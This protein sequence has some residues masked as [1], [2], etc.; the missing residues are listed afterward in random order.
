MSRRSLREAY[1]ASTDERRSFDEIYGEDNKLF[2]GAEKELINPKFSKLFEEVYGSSHPNM[3]RLRE[4]E[5]KGEFIKGILAAKEG[6]KKDEKKKPEAKKE[7]TVDE[8]LRMRE[9]NDGDYHMTRSPSEDGIEG[10]PSSL[11]SSQ[12]GGGASDDIAQ[13]EP[14]QHDDSRLFGK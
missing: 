3:R 6:E 13:T 10:I 8:F 1:S 4:A 14:N 9:A 7:S 12:M 5:E 11:N 2:E